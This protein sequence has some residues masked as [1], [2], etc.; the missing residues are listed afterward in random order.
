MTKNQPVKLKSE[1]QGELADRIRL[2]IRQRPQE[3]GGRLREAVLSRDLGVSRSPIRAALLHLVAEGILELDERGGYNVV[4]VPSVA[5]SSPDEDDP[6]SSLYVRVLKDII[7]NEI[8]DPATESAMMRRYDA[9]RGEIIRVVR[10][11]MREGLAEPLPGHGWTVLRLDSEQ[12]ARSYHLRAV[13]EPALLVDRTYEPQYAALE[14]LRNEHATMLEKM[15]PDSPWQ[16]LFEID[17]TFHELLASGSGNEMAVDIVRRQ[18]RLRRLAEYV[19]YGRLERIQ[20][21]MKEH[22]AIIDALLRDDRNWAAAMLRQHLS[23]SSTETTQN[24]A[25]DLE[26]IRAGANKLQLTE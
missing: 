19:S 22:M 13:L 14:R 10:R 11:L 6:A 3:I 15:S 23:I 21:S 1:L 9:G 20:A 4:R 17:A 2:L 26:A 5:T 24:Y 18:N 8:P 7:L 16:P 25:R 12:L